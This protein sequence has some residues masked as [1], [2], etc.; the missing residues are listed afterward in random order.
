MASGS[1]TYFAAEPSDRIG[2]IL[3]AKVDAFA[4]NKLA[5]E[6]YSRL[7]KCFLYYYGLDPSG[8]HAT[9]AILRGGEQGELAD[10]RVNHARALVN[11]LLNLIVGPS[12]VWSVKATNSDFESAGQCVLGNAILEY[13]WQDRNVGKYA[14][15]ACE[16]A[17]A[18]T[19]GF[20]FAEWDETLGEDYGVETDPETGEQSLIKTGDIR[21]TN[22]S[23]WDVIRDPRKKSWDELDWVI[24]RIPKNRHDLAAQHPE[25]FEAILDAGD[26]EEFRIDRQ[27]YQPGDDEVPD[28]VPV[29]Y[30]FHKPTPACPQGRETVFINEDCVLRDRP[31]QYDRIPLHRVHAADLIGTPFGYSPFLETLG[32]QELIDSLHSSI[33]TNQTAFATQCIAI[34]QGSE[35]PIDQ[36]AGGMRAIYY[37]PGAQPPQALQLTK[38][39]PEVF[40]HLKDLKHDQEQL[41]GLNSVVRG[42]PEGSSRSGRAL[43][44]LQSQALQQSSGIQKNWTAFVE[45]IGLAVIKMMQTRAT[46]ERRIAISGKNNRYLDRDEPFTSKSIGKISRVQVQVGN[47]MSQTA[48][49]REEIADKYI[50]LQLIKS[51]EQLQQV[52]DTGR[53]E[54]LTQ[55]ISNELLLIS[56]ENENIAKGISPPVLLHDDHRLHAREHRPA[57][58]NPQA[59][60]DEKLLTAGMQHMHDHYSALFGVLEPM[61]DPQ[62]RERML[63]MLGLGPEPMP[64]LPPGAPPPQPTEPPAKMSNSAQAAVGTATQPPPSDGVNGQLPDMPTNPISGAE[65]NPE[66]GGL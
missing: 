48:A 15:R 62:Y 61:T 39:P 7:R 6:L 47:P 31:L 9:S 56:S 46:A 66:S 51:P 29:Y 65:W 3:K 4:T 53:L 49:G 38:S 64:M 42:A 2:Q 55:S 59:R 54:P 16:E 19:E 52:L 11:T 14:I 28:D 10:V 13:Y 22:I 57:M 58:S 5:S 26:D 33:A 1:R 24:L 18:F 34:A 43:A 50:Q 37:P 36:I 63:F 12:V 23:T 45:S 8:I 35:I 21:F 25:L 17:I 32:I 20:V 27:N 41:F 30:F 44:L 60:Q 40:Q